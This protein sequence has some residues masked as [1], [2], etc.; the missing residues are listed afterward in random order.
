MS[1]KF[2]TKKLQSHTIYH[3]GGKKYKMMKKTDERII[4]INAKKIL[5]EDVEPLLN[6]LQRYFNNITTLTGSVTTKKF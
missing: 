4:F 3:G 6:M 5:S 1:H 2:H